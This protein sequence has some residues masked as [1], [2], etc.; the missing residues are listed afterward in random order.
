MKRILIAYTT[1]DGQTRKILK[2][3]ESQ[4]EGSF[5]CDFYDMKLELPVDLTQYDFI[6]IASSI[7]YGHYSKVMYDFT[8]KYK[9]ELE[10]IP[11]GFMSVNLTARKKG[12]DNPKTSAYIKKFLKK[13]VWK[14]ET[15]VM[16][17]GALLYPEYKFYDRYMIK[18][19]MFLTG[20]ETNTKKTVEY[21]DWQK[22]QGFAMSVK[23][24]FGE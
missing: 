2:T 7:R 14:P 13:S 19:I 10:Q 21:T 11:S 24:K 5:I 23:K 16:F 3:L 18:L 8:K 20:G 12:K 15:I 1:N 22:V 6:L 9:D 17:A 4:W